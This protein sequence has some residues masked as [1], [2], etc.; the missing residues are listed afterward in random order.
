MQ[1]LFLQ[2]GTV[3]FFIRCGGGGGGEAG[4]IC[5][6]PCQKIGHGGGGGGRQ[7][8]ILGVKRWSPKEFFQVLQ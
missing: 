5:G 6:G 2:L 4:G 1:H 7:K 3:H 8:K